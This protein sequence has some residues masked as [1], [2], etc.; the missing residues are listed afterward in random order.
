MNKYSTVTQWVEYRLQSRDVESGSAVR[1]GIADR[2]HDFFQSGNTRLWCGTRE[3]VPPSLFT[4]P[5]PSVRI[6]AVASVTMILAFGD[7]LLL[8][9]HAQGPALKRSI[10]PAA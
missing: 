10:S 8:D 2:L 6:G 7:R 4:G 1:A 9:Q 5:V 3:R